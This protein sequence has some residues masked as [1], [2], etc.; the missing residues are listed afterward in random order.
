MPPEDAAALD[1]RRPGRCAT[2][3]S[4]P[5]WP[6]ASAATA[7]CCAPSS[8]RR[9]LGHRLLG[10]NVGQLGYLTEVEPGAVAQRARSLRR[11]RRTRSRSGCCSRSSPIRS[12]T[13]RPC[14]WRALNEAVIEKQES[15]HTVRLL[16]R[17]RRRAVHHL[18]GR[19]PDRRH[20]DRLDRVL[21][22]GARADRV[23]PPPGPAAHPGLAAHAVRPHPRARPDA[24]RSRSRSSA[25]QR[26]PQ[27]RRAA[28]PPSPRATAALPGPPTGPLSS[29]SAPAASTRS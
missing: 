25:P 14:T 19:R 8:C 15:G 2:A 23:A 11:R 24:S 20:P 22:L 12:V 9:R 16:V 5:T 29:A 21:A 10:V 4:R 27:R 13:C 7:R 28:G 17:D 26:R 18:R 6:S 1:A 3:G